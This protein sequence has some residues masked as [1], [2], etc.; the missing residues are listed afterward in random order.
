ML[1]KGEGKGYGEERYNYCLVFCLG[2][3]ECMW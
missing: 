2:E 3:H 1:V